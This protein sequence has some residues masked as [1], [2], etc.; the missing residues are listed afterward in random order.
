MALQTIFLFSLILFASKAAAQLD[1]C[2]ADLKSPA[3]PTGYPCKNPATVTVDDFAFSST[4]AVAGNTSN[5]FKAAVATA[6]VTQ[7]PGLNGLGT[8]M[9]RVDIAVGG[10]IP[11]HTHPSGTELLLVL[12]GTI[13]AGF[14]SS[15]NNVYSKILKKGDVFVNPRGLLHFA[16]NAGQEPAV[17]IVSFSSHLPGLQPTD[18]ALF[19]NNLPTQVVKATTFLDE[20]QIK[21]LKAAFGGTN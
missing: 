1:F 7:L 15:A 16:I 5:V 6:V 11:M 2:V 12:E 4:L 19:G 13:N 3:T 17:G 20:A 18:Y 14:I 10:V 21:K 8:A 9:G